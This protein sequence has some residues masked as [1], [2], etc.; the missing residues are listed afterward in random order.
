MRSRVPRIV[1]L[2]ASM[3]G[4]AGLAQAQTSEVPTGS[5]EQTIAQWKASNATCRSQ[6]AAALAAVGACDQRDTFS[7]L[8]AQMNYCFGP[9]DKTNPATWSPCDAAKAAQDSA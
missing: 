1:A 6:T 2:A 5:A 8:L 3:C 7:K 9:A 4:V